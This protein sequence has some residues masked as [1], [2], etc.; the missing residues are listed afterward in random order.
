MKY[1]HRFPVIRVLTGLFFALYAMHALGSTFSHYQNKMQR[2][3]GY[4]V[5][6]RHYTLAQAKNYNQKGI[7]SWYGLHTNGQKTAD[8]EKYN[9]YAMTAAS[10]VLPLGTHVRV[11]N[12]ENHRSVV[13]RI[14]DRGP[15]VKGRI[16]DLSYA[17]A[18]KLGYAN[19]GITHIQVTTV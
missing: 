4:T 12:L 11:T 15:F 14:N 5:R 3:Y 6:G 10:K 8:G 2:K 19:Q 9:M 7:A 17:A 16:I 1:Q 13:V 18:K